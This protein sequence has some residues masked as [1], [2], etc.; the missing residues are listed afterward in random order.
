[1][2]IYANIFSLSASVNEKQTTLKKI[3]ALQKCIYLAFRQDLSLHVCQYLQRQQ[4]LNN[5]FL[6]RKL[7]KSL[8]L[9]LQASSELS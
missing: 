7:N 6:L 3:F 8:N 2:P 4:I 5:I 1:M 9:C